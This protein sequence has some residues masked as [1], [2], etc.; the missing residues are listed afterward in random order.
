MDVLDTLRDKFRKGMNEYTDDLAN[1]V[2]NWDAYQRLVGR[3]EGLAIAERYL[4]DLK[5]KIEEQ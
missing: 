1:G 5:E 2:S 3:I 4:L